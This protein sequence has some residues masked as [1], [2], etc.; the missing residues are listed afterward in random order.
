MREHEYTICS[1]S[2]SNSHYFASVKQIFGIFCSLDL[3]QEQQCLKPFLS[4]ALSACVNQLPEFCISLMVN[5]TLRQLIGWS[6]LEQ[7]LGWWLTELFT[8]PGRAE[9]NVAQ[10]ANELEK[11][12]G[13]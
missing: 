13:E 9:T 10:S 1:S 5:V 12:A 3:A 6:E 11:S 4:V 7:C 2:M 8:C